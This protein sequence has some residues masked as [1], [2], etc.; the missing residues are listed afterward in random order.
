MGEPGFSNESLDQQR[1]AL[2]AKLTNRI[3]TIER[4]T[5]SLQSFQNRM[6][7]E[8]MDFERHTTE[9][10]KAFLLY[11][12]SMNPEEREDAF[13]IFSDKQ[14]KKR[15]VFDKALLAKQQDWFSENV[16]NVSQTTPIDSEPS[17][18]KEVSDAGMAPQ[19]DEDKES[20]EVSI[21]QAPG[22]KEKAPPQP[23]PKGKIKKT[24]AR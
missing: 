16:K 6:K 2:E 21:L 17:A 7:K 14:A 24:A 9:E 20:A 23:K 12:K 3:A 4:N 1:A 19:G 13:K 11:L 15:A 22:S 10:E 18:V 8:R 5:E